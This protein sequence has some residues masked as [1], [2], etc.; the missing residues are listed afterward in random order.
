MIEKQSTL[1]VIMIMKSLLSSSPRLL[2]LD[3]ILFYPNP[4]LNFAGS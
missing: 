4:F 1:T 2:R 3:E